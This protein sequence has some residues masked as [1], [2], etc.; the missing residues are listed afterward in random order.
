M[1]I[2]SNQAAQSL[3]ENDRTT[4]SGATRSGAQAPAHD[5]QAK[6]A[7]ASDPL[8]NDLL[9]KD[10]LG[11]D[12]AQLSSGHLQIQ[13]LASKLL[14]LPEIRQEKVNALRQLVRDGSYNLRPNEVADAV[15]AHLLAKPAA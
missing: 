14:Q 5:V 9:T 10:P 3:R 6:D 13:A 4:E 15:F 2:D 12:Q 8:T 1:R 11:E 7:L